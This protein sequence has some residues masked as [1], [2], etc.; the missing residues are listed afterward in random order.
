MALLLQSYQ[1]RLGSDTL[2][3]KAVKRAAVLAV[4]VSAVVNP[5]IRGF[6]VTSGV[7]ERYVPSRREEQASSTRNASKVFESADAAIADLQDG[8]TVLS[9]GFGLSGVAGKRNVSRNCVQLGEK[10]SEMSVWSEQTKWTNRSRQK[11]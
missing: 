9:A 10:S 8:T 3:W 1:Q 11:H 4:T 7:R 6:G 2:C 5:Q